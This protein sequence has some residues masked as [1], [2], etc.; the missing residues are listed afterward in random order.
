MKKD[1]KIKDFTAIL[2]KSFYSGLRLKLHYS[3]IKG[4]FKFLKIFLENYVFHFFDFLCIVI[5]PVTD[6]K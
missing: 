1:K 5:F 3:L 2:L 4:N 6:Q